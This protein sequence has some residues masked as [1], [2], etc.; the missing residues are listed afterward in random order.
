MGAMIGPFVGALV[1]LA[2][3]IAEVAL[4]NRS[5]YPSLRWRYEKAKTTQ[6][7]GMSPATIIALVKFQSLVLMPL[8]GF[9]LGDRLK[10][11]FG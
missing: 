1:F 4:V 7:Q 6:S 5:V 11:L 9:L 2:I 8:F 3:G 10:T